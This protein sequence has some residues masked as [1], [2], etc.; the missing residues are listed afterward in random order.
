MASKIRTENWAQFDATL[1]LFNDSL[2]LCLRWKP[3]PDWAVHDDWETPY[4]AQRAPDRLVW[5]Q[6][7]MLMRWWL[8]RSILTLFFDLRVATTC[9]YG[10]RPPRK[11][12]LHDA[13]GEKPS[14]G[15]LKSRIVTRGSDIAWIEPSRCLIEL[16]LLYD[17]S[18]SLSEP[19][20]MKASP[21]LN[22][23]AT[24]EETTPAFIEDRTGHVSLR[25]RGWRPRDWLTKNPSDGCAALGLLERCGSE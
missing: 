13:Q 17:V 3:I 11:L 18:D 25:R 22:S 14:H 2:D 5:R 8:R 20:M 19:R 15:H 10:Y 21:V 12:A 6:I 24:T 1:A 16:E 7:T 4:V 23:R 9:T